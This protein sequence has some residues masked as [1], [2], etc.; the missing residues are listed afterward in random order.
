MPW[1]IKNDLHER[2]RSRRE[3]VRIER[4]R[5]DM[6]RERFEDD[7]R[8]KRLARNMEYHRNLLRSRS[9]PG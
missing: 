5:L 7:E 4:E 1:S 2:E 6:E 8:W 9:R 3:A